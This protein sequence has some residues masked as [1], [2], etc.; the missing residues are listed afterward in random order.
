MAA[1]LYEIEFKFEV[2][3]PDENEDLQKQWAKSKIHLA[4]ETF[5]DAYEL[6]DSYLE[7]LLEDR[8]YEIISVVGHDD[9][10]I[11]NA[12]NEDAHQWE[13]GECPFCA[14][15]GLALDLVM[16]FKCPHC[17]QPI[18]VGDTGWEK[19]HCPHC[20]SVLERGHIQR[21]TDGHL[22]YQIEN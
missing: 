2:E 6:G 8:T 17:V 7:E 21:H 12:G 19:I 20:D 18:T 11:L 16:R 15:E 10:I 4:C 22:Y 14:V 5:W 1:I 3:V 9:I 13:G